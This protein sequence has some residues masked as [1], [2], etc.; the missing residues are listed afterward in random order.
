M[1][2]IQDLL[3]PIVTEHPKDGSGA[4]GDRSSRLDSI[5]SL[6][7]I[8]FVIEYIHDTIC[9]FCYIGF[10]TLLQAIGEFKARHPHAVFEVT[11]SPFILGPDA[12]VSAWLATS[13]RR[14]SLAVSAIPCPAY[15]KYD[16]YIKTR[17]LPA[18]RISLWSN[19]G[20]SVGIRFR[21][22]GLTGNSRDSHKL[23]RFALEEH[24]TIR[25]SSTA[26]TSRAAG[27]D[28]PPLY[29][30]SILRAPDHPVEI[31]QPRG[32]DLQMRLLDAITHAY[33]EEDRDLSDPAMLL[34]ITARVTG[35][36]RQAIQEVLDSEE[37]DRAIDALSQEV[38]TRREVQNRDL[39]PIVA[40]PTMVINN[41]WV[42]GGFQTVGDLVGQFELLAKGLVPQTEY[43]R[44]QMVPM[45][46]TADTLARDRLTALR[47]VEE[48]E[49]LV[50]ARA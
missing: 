14:R 15:T 18:D 30:P 44:S 7:P 13:K 41:Q 21:W 9:P 20:A 12:L 28:P 16:Y 39:G 17:G 46:G 8:T 1:S 42:Y 4:D 11:C 6:A 48:E 35:F 40:V 31:E 37:W 43:T 10:R 3:S 27:R 26:F 45:A 50:R 32:P 24:P 34:E 49:L 29:P 36:S 38:Q 19:L 47:Q 5:N 2:S 33:H 23:L 25:R 22:E